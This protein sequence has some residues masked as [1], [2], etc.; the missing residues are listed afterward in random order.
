MVLCRYAIFALLSRGILALP[1]E[2]NRGS[3]ADPARARAST[4]AVL[5]DSPTRNTTIVIVAVVMG[6]RGPALRNSTSCRATA[7]ASISCS[8]NRKDHMLESFETRRVNPALRER[9]AP[10]NLRDPQIPGDPSFFF[11]PGE[12]SRLEKADDSVL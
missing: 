1:E 3:F 4:F 7:D 10:R 5:L 9:A 2:Q 8:L 12:A 6:N 11:I